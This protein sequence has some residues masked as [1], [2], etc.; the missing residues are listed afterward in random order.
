MK[1]HRSRWSNGQTV[2][3]GQADSANGCLRCRCVMNRSFDLGRCSSASPSGGSAAWWCRW[4]G[5]SG[6]ACWSNSLRL[7]LR[8]DGIWQKLLKGL[9]GCCHCPGSSAEALA[10]G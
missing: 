4:P 2:P 5:Q 7:E 6:S 10:S 9:D 3:L 1:T 8:G